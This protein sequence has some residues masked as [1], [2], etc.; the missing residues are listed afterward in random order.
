MMKI[1][2]LKCIKQLNMG[3]VFIPDLFPDK[4]TDLNQQIIRD[5]CSCLQLTCFS[6]RL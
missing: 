5:D 1:R 6:N 2:I 4:R 3:Y